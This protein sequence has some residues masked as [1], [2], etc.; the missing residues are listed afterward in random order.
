MVQN[1]GHLDMRPAISGGGYVREGVGRLAINVQMIF[2]RKCSNKI[3]LDFFRLEMFNSEAK[4]TKNLWQKLQLRN[5][6]HHTERDGISWLPER[7]SLDPMPAGVCRRSHLIFYMK[8]GHNSCKR[9]IYIYICIYIYI[10]MI[11]CICILFHSIY[12]A[13]VTRFQ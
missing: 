3:S 12:T 2:S 10:Y 8:H 11:A 4:E 6:L 13:W 7:T 1:A 5:T 9:Q